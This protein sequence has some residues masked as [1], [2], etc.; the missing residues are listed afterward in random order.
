MIGFVALPDPEYN[1]EQY[2]VI[3]RSLPDF[4]GLWV[5]GIDIDRPALKRPG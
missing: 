2:Q 1:E 3:T 5:Q 4:S